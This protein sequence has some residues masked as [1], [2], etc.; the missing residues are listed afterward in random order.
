MLSS[1]AWV[2]MATDHLQTGGISPLYLLRGSGHFKMA[3]L[4]DAAWHKSSS[5]AAYWACISV[6]E[7]DRLKEPSC[8]L[9]QSASGPFSNE[10]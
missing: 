1:C 5:Q 8:H 3:K 6:R 2:T 4:M 9:F 7:M 10:G